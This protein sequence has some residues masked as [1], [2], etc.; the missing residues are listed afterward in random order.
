ME[1]CHAPP[2]SCTPRFPKANARSPGSLFLRLVSV[3]GDGEAVRHRLSRKML[4]ANQDDV[5][6]ML[7]RARLLT[8]SEDALEVAHEAL[9]RALAPSPALAGGGPGWPA[10]PRPS[11]H[12]GRGLG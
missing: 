12:V 2:K 8:A 5:V 10:H 4:A 3:A 9:A 6:N 1:R 7:V 11:V